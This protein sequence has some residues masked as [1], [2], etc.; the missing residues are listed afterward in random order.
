MY[1]PLLCLILLP[2]PPK[3]NLDVI[4]LDVLCKQYRVLHEASALRGDHKLMK[5]AQFQAQRMAAR[6]GFG[7][8]DLDN[9]FLVDLLA[10]VGYEYQMAG[11]IVVANTG[12]TDPVRAA[13]DAWAASAP[14]RQHLLNKELRRQGAG[15][16]RAKSGRWYFVLVLVR[17]PDDKP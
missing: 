7:A 13:V 17:R 6:D 8:D 9:S 14:H 10:A 16:A 12:M 2:D 3:Q 5:V 15:V 11:E 1:T 4:K